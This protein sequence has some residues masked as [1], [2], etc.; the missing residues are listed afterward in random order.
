MGP[1]TRPVAQWRKSMMLE[2]QTKLLADVQLVV[3]APRCIQAALEERVGATAEWGREG[4]GHSTRLEGRLVCRGGRTHQPCEPV[5]T[6][7][8]RCFGWVG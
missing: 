1:N 2:A 4:G 5:A 6:S 8:R 3:D 7:L